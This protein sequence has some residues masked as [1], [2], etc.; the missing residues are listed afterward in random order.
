MCP[1]S[2]HHDSH[3]LINTLNIFLDNGTD[4]P[5]RIFNSDSNFLKANPNF[6][7][8]LAKESLKPMLET[9]HMIT[10]ALSGFI[11][12]SLIV[13]TILLGLSRMK[14]E[15][16]KNDM[17]LRLVGYNLIGGTILVSVGII[18]M[19]LFKVL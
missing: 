6:S 9:I 10:A 1:F 18:S 16:I 19:V 15:T 14:A 13:A 3:F 7:Q 12:Y 2:F 11:L 8:L 5:L 17:H 4:N